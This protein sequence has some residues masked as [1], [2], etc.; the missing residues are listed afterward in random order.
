[1]VGASIKQ[2]NHERAWLEN[3]SHS[4]QVDV[5]CE[6]TG[7]E[8]AERLY[9][10]LSEQVR[11]SGFHQIPASL[12]SHTTLTLFVH[13]R[14]TRLTSRGPKAFCPVSARRSKARPWVG[15]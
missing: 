12:F 4:V 13:N 11:M 5:T 14:S 9:Q 15:W 1:V 2:I 8:M 10:A 3:D 6:L 7:P